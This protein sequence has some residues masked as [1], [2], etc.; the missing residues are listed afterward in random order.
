MNLC[1]FPT[2]IRRWIS[3][4]Y[5]WHLKSRLSPWLDRWSRCRISVQDQGNNNQ[6]QAGASR[7]GRVRI[8]IEGNNNRI[9]FAENC[10]FE[11]LD[12][13][14]YGSDNEIQIGTK[15][16]F[17]EGAVYLFSNRG[18]L[19]IAGQS[20]FAGVVFA[21]AEPDTSIVVGSGCMFSNFIEVRTGDSHGVYPVGGGARL[22]PGADV[23]VGPSVWVGTRCLLLKGTVIP[24]G[25]IVGA[26]SMVNRAHETEHAILAGQPARIIR[27]GVTW[28]RDLRPFLDPTQE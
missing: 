12:I 1:F 16:R 28:C 8:T 23:V 5:R 2:A 25:C 11:Q 10:F 18:K 14:I 19:E 22:N 4:Q 17:R 15:T 9:D 7:Y 6:V 20:T 24:K 27:E 26:G 21:V 13:W 3:N